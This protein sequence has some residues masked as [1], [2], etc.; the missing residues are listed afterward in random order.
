[1]CSIIA[2]LKYIDDVRVDFDKVVV[3]RRAVVLKVHINKINY[4]L[5]VQK[6]IDKQQIVRPFDMQNK[7]LTIFKFMYRFLYFKIIIY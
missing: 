3:G 6:P 2:N 1:M 7:E 4:N 5:K